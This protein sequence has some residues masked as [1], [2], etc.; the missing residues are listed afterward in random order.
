MYIYMCCD[1]CYFLC[2]NSL[3]NN[4]F[5]P[6]QQSLPVQPLS[7]VQVPGDVHSVQ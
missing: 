4:L 5:I 7:H 6:V 2:A 3:S 1:M